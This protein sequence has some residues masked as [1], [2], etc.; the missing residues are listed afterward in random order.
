MIAS[1]S[2]TIT[3]IATSRVIIDVHGIGFEVLMPSGDIAVLHIGD[4]V[5]VKTVLNF[6][7]DSFTLYGFTH[8]SSQQLFVQLQKVSGIGPKVALAI[9]STFNAQELAESISKAD[10]S[11]LCKAPGLGRKGAQKIILELQGVL[12]LESTS[13][14]DSNTAAISVM[15]EQVVAGL[16]SLGWNLQDAQW[17]TKEAQLRLGTN[18]TSAPSVANVL[19]AALSLLDRRR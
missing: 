2:G 10:V 14:K 8:Q 19:R 16:T 7:Q 3:D 15:E 1:L 18:E 4:R 17:A 13:S 12:T 9:L 6:S 11:A 5:S